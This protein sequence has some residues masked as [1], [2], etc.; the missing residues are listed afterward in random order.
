MANLPRV[1]LI[2][3]GGT[4]DSVGKD[5]LDLAWYIE[6]GKRLNDGELLEQLPELKGIAEIQ[7]I[8]FRRLPSHALVDKDWLDLVRTIHKIFDEDKADGI[9]ITH[10]TNTIEETAYFLN[11]V[12]KT[13][14]PVVV[15]GSM[16]PSSAISADGYLNLVNA[17]K[18]A[19]DPSSKGRGCLL[20]MN[21]T[22]FNGRD[23]TKTATYRVEAFQS[24]D[25]GPL[26]FAD[27]DGKIVYYHT[28][29]RKHTTATE[30]D[31]R[32]LASLP[33]VDMVLSYVG[34]DGTMI[35]AA[36]KA[37][38]KGIVS[39]GTGA[40]RPTPAED[41]AFD[42]CFKETGMLMCLCS[43]VAARRGVRSPG[44]QRRGVG[45]GDNQQPWKARQ[46]LAVGVSKKK[47]H[48]EIQRMLDT[49]RLQP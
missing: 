20:V 8:P 33:R 4:I 7:E 15:V 32:K 28:P 18:V 46:R 27:G 25:L 16:R 44:L 30:F 10:G 42:K 37:G 11:L 26:G 12:L 45:A 21:D 34:A 19:A 31:V 24:R 43:R 23:V 6:A 14:K 17:V 36:A 22:I 38:A 41:A 49:Y 1:A 5:R 3:T 40:G 35:E 9:V 2:L 39:A 47:Y 13:H 29:V 48:D